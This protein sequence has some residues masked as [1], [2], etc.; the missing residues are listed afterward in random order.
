M[1]LCKKLVIVGVSRKLNKFVKRPFYNC[2]LGFHAVEICLYE[3][4]C[5][6]IKMMLKALLVVYLFAGT[7]PRFEVKVYYTNCITLTSVAQR[8]K[9]HLRR[10]RLRVRF[11]PRGMF[12]RSADICLRCSGRFLCII[13][14]LSGY[15]MYYIKCILALLSLG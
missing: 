1:V 11:P 3:C 15:V 14:I 9:V 7:V 6:K 12:V 2:I 8:M 13:I 4:C 10:R 5:W